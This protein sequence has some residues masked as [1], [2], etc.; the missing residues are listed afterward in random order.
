MLIDTLPATIEVGSTDALLFTFDPTTYQNATGDTGLRF[1]TSVLTD[2]STT[3]N[4]VVTLSDV[5][6]VSGGLITQMLRG[7]ALTVGHTYSLVIG[8]TGTP[9]NAVWSMRTT[10]FCP[11]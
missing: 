5:P 2:T 3:P 8:Y 1:P 7:S 4:S 11:V 6:S 9:S 10:V